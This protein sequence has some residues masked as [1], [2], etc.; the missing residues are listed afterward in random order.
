MINMYS[1]LYTLLKNLGIEKPEDMMYN[2]VVFFEK[3]GKDLTEEYKELE[4]DE[5]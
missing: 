2:D 5:N 4:Y 3:L 1:R